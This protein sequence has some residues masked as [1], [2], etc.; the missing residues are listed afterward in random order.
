MKRIPERIRKKIKGVNQTLIELL[1][2]IIIITLF[3]GVLALIFAPSKL[4]FCA[5]LFIGAVIACIWAI[6]MTMT[7]ETQMELPEGDAEKYARRNYA[8][9][10]IFI[11]VALIFATRFEEIHIIA[12]LLGM[13]TLKLAV[14]IRPL[15]IKLIAKT[16]SSKGR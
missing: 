9:R 16:K 8:L 1:I 15:T 12:L 2:G 11:M 6:S 3:I 5:S 7:I 10:L 14:Y 13:L 4:Q